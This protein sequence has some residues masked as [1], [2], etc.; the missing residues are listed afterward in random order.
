MITYKE[1]GIEVDGQFIPLS[2]I[3]EK[4]NLAK[5]E[6]ENLVIF[7]I[8]WSGRGGHSYEKTVYPKAVAKKLHKLL[9]GKFVYLG[10]VWG[11]HSEV[12]GDLEEKDMKIITDKKEVKEFLQSNPSGSDYSESFIYSL[13][14]WYEDNGGR[15]Y[16]EQEKDETYC[17][18]VEE[19]IKLS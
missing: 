12:Y 18:E 8:E 16:W 1:N 17:N 19:I 10:E 5:I 15:E 4:C 3:T 13:Q 7:Q 2:E 14:E 9:L 11:K 6:K